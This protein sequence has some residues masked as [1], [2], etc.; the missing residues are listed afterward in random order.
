[1]IGRNPICMG[2]CQPLSRGS[3]SIP[4]LN[5][6]AQPKAITWARPD[7]AFSQGERAESSGDLDFFILLMSHFPAYL[8]THCSP[9]S[10]TIL[11]RRIIRVI[12]ERN[13][14]RFISP[15]GG[16]K[17]P[18]SRAGWVRRWQDLLRSEDGFLCQGLFVC[19]QERMIW[20]GTEIVTKAWTKACLFQYVSCKIGS[21]GNKCKGEMK[22]GAGGRMYFLLLL[23]HWHFVIFFHALIPT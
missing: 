2:G 6:H 4:V 9:W 12:I 19:L 18:H 8:W 16:S 20:H 13:L 11:L 3:Q 7:S 14:A 21:W 22:E 10:K 1:M 5:C 23:W 17:E 15:E